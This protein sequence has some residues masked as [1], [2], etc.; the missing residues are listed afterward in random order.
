M[1][2]ASE[3]LTIDEE[4]NL[5]VPEIEELWWQFHDGVISV[6]E[7]RNVLHAKVEEAAA[8]VIGIVK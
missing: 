4:R 3:R 1:T 6:V 2:L 5:T 8:K 7:F